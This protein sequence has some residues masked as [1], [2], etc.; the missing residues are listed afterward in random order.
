MILA[1]HL[2]LTSTLNH[3]GFPGG[4]VVEN[5]T[6]NAGDRGLINE[7]RRSP[8]RELATHSSIL[9]WEIP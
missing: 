4:S 8:G 9:A 6:V 2:V 5:I 1:F 3:L 7:S